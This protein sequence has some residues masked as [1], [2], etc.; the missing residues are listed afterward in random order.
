MLSKGG[1]RKRGRPATTPEQKREKARLRQARHRRQVA[2]EQ[3]ARLTNSARIIDLEVLH[4][5]DLLD[6]LVTIK[7][8]DP[9][10]VEN[11]PKIEDAVG[12]LLKRHLNE[13][14]AWRE[15]TGGL[16]SEY[17]YNMMMPCGPNFRPRSA[18]SGTVRVRVAIDDAE[19]LEIDID[20]A[21]QMKNHLEH[22]LFRILFQHRGLVSSAG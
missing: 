13:L 3:F 6:F 2:D 15:E 5:L 4:W 9:R 11:A 17:F 19:A 22:V 1:G 12:E 18:E 21:R 7:L 20:D 14:R 16:G 10:N 8:L